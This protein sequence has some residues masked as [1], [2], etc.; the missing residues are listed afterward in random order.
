MRALKTVMQVAF[1]SPASQAIYARIL[2]EGKD[3]EGNPVF[4]AGR[5]DLLLGR[6][7]ATELPGDHPARQ[8]KII[9]KSP[10]L[11]YEDE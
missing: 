5:V 11:F 7:I 1:A 9:H 8:I 2:L 3:A 6:R 4:P 10:V